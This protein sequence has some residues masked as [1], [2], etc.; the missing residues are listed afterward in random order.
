[1]IVIPKNSDYRFDMRRQRES[2]KLLET[3][4]DV[5]D[6]L[7]IQAVCDLTGARYKVVWEWGKD[8]TFPSPYF[9]VMTWALNKKRLRAHP[10]LWRQVMTPE[11]ELEAA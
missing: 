1:M 5:L 7:G 11:M 9:L 3:T 6:A 2:Q 10:R 8:E 4:G